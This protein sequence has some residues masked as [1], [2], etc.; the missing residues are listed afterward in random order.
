MHGSTPVWKGFFEDKYGAIVVVID[1]TLSLGDGQAAQFI[2][3]SIWFQNFPEVTYPYSPYASRQGIL[4]TCWEITMGPYDC[5]TFLD[6]GKVRLTTSLYPN[7]RG[8]DALQ[9]YRKLGE[10][11]GLSRASA[12]F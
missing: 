2:G 1:R 3:G 6:D 10:F 4:K 7:N 12:G 9:N 8:P 5:R 11:N